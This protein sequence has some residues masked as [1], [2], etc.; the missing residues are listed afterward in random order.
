[1]DV[2]LW[3]ELVPQRAAGTERPRRSGV[4]LLQVPDLSVINP[5]SP[6][7]S[8]PLRARLYVI[9]VVT[10]AVVIGTADALIVPGRG[11]MPARD[12]IMFIGVIA[13]AECLQ[14]RFMHH[15]EVHALTL[16]EGIF[17]PLIFCGSGFDTVVAVA[18]GMILASIIRRNDAVKSL[19]NVA[20]WVAAAA[21][22]SMAFHVSGA[23]GAP[24]S[25]EV[26][27][28]VGALL[29]VWLTNQIL[30]SG[31][32]WCTTGHM[33]GS[34]DADVAGMVVLG[35]TGSFVGSAILGVLM[36]GAYLWVPWTV[37]L[38]IG[39]LVF[40]WSAS[41]AEASIRADRRLLDG[42]Q[43]AT[44]HLATS[45]DPAVALPPSLA[46][47]R[48]GFGVREVQL[49]LVA[50]HGFPTIY[51]C[52]EG[53]DSYSVETAPHGL[54]ELLVDSLDG[55]IRLGTAGSDVAVALARMGY[56]RG[57]AAPLRSGGATFGVLLLLD[58]EGAEG[59]EAG[60]LSIAGALARE[61]VGFLDRVELVGAI[62]EERRKLAD[63]VEHTGDGIVSL[64]V[65]GTVL[66]WNAAMTVIT[67]YS[68]EEM[69]DTRHIGLLRPRD[70]RDADIHI[71]GWG[72]R[73]NAGGLASELQIVTAGG[74]TVWLSCSYSHVPG[75]DGR[76][77]SL[78]IVARNITK[79]RELELL[80]DDFIAVVSHE[81]RTPLVPIKGWAQTLLNRG[82]R[83]TEDQRRTA[84]QSI[85]TQ[86]QRLEALVL[87]I[88]ESSR[89]EAGQG[90]TLDI[91]DVASVAVHVV[92][93]VLAARPDRSIR[94]QPPQVPCQV[95]GSA[96]WV[97][98]ALANLVANAVKYSPDDSP[99]DVVVSVEAGT[100]SVSVT[101]RGPGISQEA[102]ERIFER[103]ERLEE[104]RKQTG[105]GLGLYITRRLA[106]A[107]GGDVAVSSLPGAGS[108]FVLSLPAVVEASVAASAAAHRTTSAATT[109]TGASGAV[110]SQAY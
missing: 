89:V 38:V 56:Q 45:L 28:L 82:E 21:V 60:E 15:D 99:V 80:K 86:A 20:Q 94:V 17:A 61:L 25:A 98:R 14:L 67:G 35:R 58:R 31:V 41:R 50:E 72:E 70:A 22:G 53:G 2:A 62:D 106:R 91:V 78:I 105:T 34:H 108:T 110:P 97:D 27:A 19:F 74:A 13:L 100:V 12:V 32:M 40:L 8:L 5:R 66:S 83:L 81:L 65:D 104:S 63:I 10:A 30:F 52:Y 46:E 26:V 37:V 33:L 107:M 71:A 77:D 16:V 69:V 84:V 9:A 87:N 64:A 59:F 4:R 11:E 79:A 90:Q 44:H 39:L 1:M 51:H 76:L 36:V 29:A 102:Q 103:F 54:A 42:L 43:R 85:L 109:P 18:G 93:D 96:V 3:L 23:G 6:R 49:V 75:K 48:L 95:R 88:L 47:T 7:R 24:S 55:P 57:L 68:A 92:E 101:D 73:M